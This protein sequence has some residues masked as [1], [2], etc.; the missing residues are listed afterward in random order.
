MYKELNEFLIWIT[1]VVLTIGSVLGL[2][3]Y[4]SVSKHKEANRLFPKRN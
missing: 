1:I 3:P 4:K 2:L